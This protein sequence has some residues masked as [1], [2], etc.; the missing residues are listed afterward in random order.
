MIIT[1]VIAL[2]ATASTGQIKPRTLWGPYGP[3]TDGIAARL[4]SPGS[5]TLTEGQTFT[6]QI[7]GSDADE[8][9]EITSNQ[10][11]LHSFIGNWQ[12]VK[13]TTEST[14]GSADV[15]TQYVSGSGANVIIKFN[16]VTRTFNLPAGSYPV[17]GVDSYTIYDGQDPNASPT[18]PGY[19]LWD[20]N[21]VNIGVNFSINKHP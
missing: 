21:E 6:V 1:A 15:S 19:V 13:G 14:P 2:A 3:W 8:Y 20:S 16:R 9:V 17:T 12:T 5:L 10:N 4:N 7:T 11:P 18:N